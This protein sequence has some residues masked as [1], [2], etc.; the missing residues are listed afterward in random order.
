MPARAL[1]ELHS[2]DSFQRP[3]T[4]TKFLSGRLHTQFLPKRLPTDPPLMK[5]R[6]G[7]TCGSIWLRWFREASYN[8]GMPKKK[9][10]QPPVKES[11]SLLGW[12]ALFA[13]VAAIVVFAFVKKSDQPVQTAETPAATQT[14]AQPPA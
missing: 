4:E 8:R 7:S 6:R 12:M 3:P 5:I 13:V 11:S 14:P 1:P 10:P 9:E 2:P